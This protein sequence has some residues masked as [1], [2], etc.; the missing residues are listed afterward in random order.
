MGIVTVV[1]ILLLRYVEAD[2]PSCTCSKFHYE[3]QMLEKMVRMEFSVERMKQDMVEAKEAMFKKLEAFKM[4]YEKEVANSKSELL[5]LNESLIT[6]TVAFKARLVRNQSPQIDEVIVFTEPLFNHGGHY[7]NVTGVFTAP[8]AG[9]YLFTIQLSLYTGKTMY[10]S[11]VVDNER[12]TNGYFYEQN[13]YKSNTADAIV[14]LNK[15]SRV[16]VKYMR[17][18]TTGSVVIEGNN[19]YRWN[20]FSGILIHL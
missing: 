15:G 8:V 20:T 6:P 3:E 19:D 14:V 17:G 9:N 2:E 16:W 7:D 5:K 11:I 13:T 1:I 18:S 12:V 4:E 10:F